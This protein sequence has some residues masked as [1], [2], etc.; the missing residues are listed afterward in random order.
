MGRVDRGARCGPGHATAGIGASAGAHRKHLLHVRHPGRVETQ[1]LVER[2]SPL[3]HCSHILDT[4]RVEYQ[5][6]VEGP[7]LNKHADHTRD[8]GRVEYQRLVE[9]RGCPKHAGHIRDTGRVEYQRLV[10]RL[11]AL[12][13]RKG[14]TRCEE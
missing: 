12:Q 5:R 7:R 3:E 4:G 9:G 8:T 2:F 13:S 1:W 14:V 10:E 6:L 11:R